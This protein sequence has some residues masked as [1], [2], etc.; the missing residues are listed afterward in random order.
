MRTKLITA[1]LS[2]GLLAPLSALAY[3]GP[4]YLSPEDIL[5][6]GAFLE[7]P[8]ARDAKA[9]VEA[10]TN[11]SAER[12]R[13]EF[14]EGY[15]IQ[16]P[17][18][19]E[20]VVEV[21]ETEESPDLTAEDRKLLSTLRLLNRIEDKQRT[22]SYGGDARLHGGAYPLAPTGP[23]AILSALAMMG[24]TGWTLMY[25]RGTGKNVWRKKKI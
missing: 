6:H 14:E 24:A 20:E 25:A 13:I 1:A 16:H 10:Q 21:A 22:L 7:P 17:P 11:Y 2:L 4:N 19:P 23:G 15:A 5:L 8:S 18:E 12:R 9:A 3:A